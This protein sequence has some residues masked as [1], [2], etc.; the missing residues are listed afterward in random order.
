MGEQKPKQ[1]CAL[2]KQA[3]IDCMYVYSLCVQ[4]GNASFDDCIKMDLENGTMNSEC[5]KR[6]TQFINCWSQIVQLSILV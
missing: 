6:W 5:K 1:I 4:S 2:Q 3:F